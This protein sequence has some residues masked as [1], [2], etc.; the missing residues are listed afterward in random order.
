MKEKLSK[1][2]HKS[3]STSTISRHL[4]EYGYKN[5]LPQST[6]ILTSDEKERHAKWAKKHT[7]EKTDELQHFLGEKAKKLEI[8]MTNNSDVVKETRYLYNIFFMSQSKE[9]EII[10][11]HSTRRGL[12]TTL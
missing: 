1:V 4:H 10:V 6:H 2:Y 12:S 7:N 3:V 9:Y 5:V 11:L 8:S